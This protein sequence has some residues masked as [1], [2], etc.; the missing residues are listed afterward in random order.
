MNASSENTKTLS[1]RAAKSVRR[2]LKAAAHLFGEEGYQ[3]ATMKAVAHAAGVS[4]GLLHYHFRS[5]E[6]LLIEAQRAAFKQIHD[7][8]EVKFQKGDAGLETALEGLD[9]L[10]E[11][12]RDLRAWTPF[13]VETM[14]LTSQEQPVRR[15][16]DDFYTESM[17]LLT[18]GISKT[19]ADDEAHL[20][21]PPHRLAWMV[22]TTLHGLVVE[23]AYARSSN[24]LQT[25][26]QIYAD[27]RAG[28]ARFVF[29]PT[30]LA[31]G[32]T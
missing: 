4:K 6:H 19:F 3:G 26:D 28:F 30:H 29:R 13:M 17:D 9:M 25:I 23:L 1:P 32:A 22:R 8:F 7:R 5:K 15:L 31:G 21:V 16:L 27:L 11:S 14:S 10:W 12:V 24:D 2:I 18:R 20:S